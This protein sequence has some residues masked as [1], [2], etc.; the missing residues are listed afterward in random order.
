[1]ASTARSLPLPPVQPLEWR[2]V[3][4]TTLVAPDD[5]TPAGE[6]V[7]GARYRLGP[8]GLAVFEAS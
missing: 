8:H 4:D 7:G 2:R 1:M 5:I 6:P 3:A